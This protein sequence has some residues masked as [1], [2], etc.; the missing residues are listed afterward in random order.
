MVVVVDHDQVTKLQVTGGRGGLR[1]DALHGTSITE[2]AVGV[3]VDQVVS[4]LVEDGTGVSLGNGKTDGVGETLAERTSGNLNTGGV[5][6]LGVTRKN[7]VNL[8][9]FEGQIELAAVISVP[10]GLTRKLL[11]S[12][13]V[14]A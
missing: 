3:V 13:M 1:G 8:L 11:M 4:G 6:G 2:E 5:V 10:I 14:M 9:F 7:A 12:S